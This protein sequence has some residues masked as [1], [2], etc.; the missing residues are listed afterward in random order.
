MR[1]AQTALCRTSAGDAAGL[2]SRQRLVNRTRLR[3]RGWIALIGATPAHAM[4]L[5]GD[6]GEVEEVGERAGH[7]QRFGQRHRRQLERQIV[8]LAVTRL[9]SRRLRGVADLFDPLVERLSLLMAERLAQQGSQ[10]AY[11][12]AQRLVRI[13]GV[14]CGITCGRGRRV[15]ELVHD[16]AASRRSSLGYCR[17]K[18]IRLSCG[19]SVPRAADQRLRHRSRQ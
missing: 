7:R 3:R 8:E 1:S 4:M 6:V 12:V 13:V 16:G 14:K 2:Q 5:L 15:D 17:A 11:V 19:W 10:Q 18:E 9:R